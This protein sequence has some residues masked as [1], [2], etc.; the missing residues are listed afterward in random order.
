MT[1]RSTINL[2]R[3]FRRLNLSVANY[4]VVRSLVYSQLLRIFV[5]LDRRE[6]GEESEKTFPFQ[7]SSPSAPDTSLPCRVP[8]SL[9]RRKTSLSTVRDRHR[10]VRDRSAPCT[11]LAS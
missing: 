10:R 7:R 2:R 11:T 3:P 4:C 8:F 5:E 1:I 6:R 9:D